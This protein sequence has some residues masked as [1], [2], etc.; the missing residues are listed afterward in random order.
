M[1]RK[2]QL[3]APTALTLEKKAFVASSYEAVWP[4]KIDAK[5]SVFNTEKVDEIL[6]LL[7]S[8]FIV[9]L[10]LNTVQEICT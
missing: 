4:P 5:K 9:R 2:N 6:P 8:A 7:I 1:D 3:H 10:Q